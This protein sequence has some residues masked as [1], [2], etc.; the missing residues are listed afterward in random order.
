[1]EILTHR[2]VWTA[3]FMSIFLTVGRRWS[4]LKTANRQT[5]G[6]VL[7]ASVLVALNWLIYIIAIN[8]GHVADAALGYFINPLVSVFLGVLF[9]SE[10]LRRLQVLSIALAA[11]A[12]LLLTFLG[13][14]PPIIALGLAFSFGFYGLVK[15]RISMSSP[16]SLTGET[17]VLAPF[18]VTYMLYLELTGPG[19]FIDYGAGHF[20]LL[21]SAGLVTAL[22]LL[23][24]GT[25]TK[26]IS[27]STIG[28]L[29]YLTPTMQMLWAVFVVNEHIAPLRWVGFIIIWG[30]VALYLLD[31]VL[32]STRTANRPQAA[33][34]GSASTAKTSGAADNA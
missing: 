18:A 8:S 34:S 29:Q 11:I 23:L 32:H 14:Q 28:M 22:P 21:L 15:K 9:L 24:F 33:S 17:L 7:L 16:A 31:I 20:A 25:A 1:M 6:W 10:R 3:V 19:T 27:L 5:W 4:E 26:H 12:V 30:A 13:G 2:I